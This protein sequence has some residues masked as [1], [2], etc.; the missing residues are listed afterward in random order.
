M[1]IGEAGRIAGLEERVE[2]MRSLNLFSNTFM[3]VALRDR[4]ACQYVLRTLLGKP[5]LVV[6]SV[7]TQ[8]RVSRLVSKD[9]ALDVLAEDQDGKLYN[10]EVQRAD[11]VDHARRVRYYGSMIDSEFL[12]KGKKYSAL[13]DVYLIYVSETD[14]W[15][16]GLAAYPVRRCFQNLEHC[17]DGVKVLYANAAVDD[18]SQR[19]RMLRYFR[20]ADP[21]DRSQGAL[22]ERGHLLKREEGG[23]REM[24][25]E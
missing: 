11:T 24:E 17:E 10:L 16:Y 3:S 2:W 25:E 18:G 22:S 7:R 23:Y 4:E 15:K 5:D 13:P 14:L 21:E 8:Y 9:S 1:S 6:R 12:E 19:A 20:T